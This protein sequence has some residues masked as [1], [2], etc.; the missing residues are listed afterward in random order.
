MLVGDEERVMFVQPATSEQCLDLK[1]GGALVLCCHI[2][3]LLWLQIH[4]NN[5]HE[6]VHY[7]NA[8]ILSQILSGS[9]NLIFFISS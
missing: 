2:D 5:T 7:G 8:K 1:R 9:D 6:K 3:N 4:S